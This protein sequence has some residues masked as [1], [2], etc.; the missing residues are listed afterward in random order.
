MVAWA[1]ENKKTLIHLARDL[2]LNCTFF[3]GFGLMELDGVGVKRWLYK[4]GIMALRWFLVQ[5]WIIWRY[6][7]IGPGWPWHLER[8]FWLLRSLAEGN[9][10]WIFWMQLLYLSSTSCLGAASRFGHSVTC[11]HDPTWCTNLIP[12]W[13]VITCCLQVS[14]RVSGFMRPVAATASLMAWTA[15]SMDALR[16]KRLRQGRKMAW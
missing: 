11:Q 15:L 5:T 2:D 12:C 1:K 3:L 10:V 14:K 16:G 9:Q 6:W 8:R 7:L 13:W 4:I